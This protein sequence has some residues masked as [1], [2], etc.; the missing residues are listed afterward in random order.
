MFSK[1]DKI[2]K[3]KVDLNSNR[4]P[5]LPTGTGKMSSGIISSQLAKLIIQF[6]SILVLSRLFSPKD[7]GVVA[8]ATVGT[9]LLELVRDRGLTNILISRS[10]MGASEI[11]FIGRHQAVIA[12]V[13]WILLSCFGFVLALNPD[14]RS[15]EMG[16]LLIGAIP[17]IS[18]L[19][20]PSLVQLS[21]EKK[22]FSQNIADILGYL[23]GFACAFISA[24]NGFGVISLFLQ[25]LITSFVS[26]IVRFIAKPWRIF[27]PIS[28]EAIRELNSDGRYYLASNSVVLLASNSDSL[29]LAANST[30]IFLG[31]YNRFFQIS[32]GAAGQ[33]LTSL[34]F[35]VLSQFRE[36]KNEG[37]TVRP[38]VDFYTYRIGIPA[39]AIVGCAIPFNASFVQLALGEQWVPY[40]TI[41]T[42]LSVGALLQIHTYIAYWLSLTVL[43]SSEIFRLNLKTRIP[44]ALMIAAASLLSAGAV[45]MA[46]SLGQ[47][48]IWI[49]TVRVIGGKQRV[50]FAQLS[51][52]G[53][54]VLGICIACFLFALFISNLKVVV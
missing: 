46:Y 27:G 30:S 44:A 12:S 2:D 40:S 4:S 16:F 1:N 7:F 18:S 53:F 10:K 21:I 52:S 24:I 19:Q 48:F 23:V 49:E 51:K 3:P 31:A 22:F 25:P 42:I 33:V 41:F 45:A 5:V 8:I 6:V 14:F 11:Y 17:V 28:L 35:L 37:K 20:M 32:V 54:A 50:A 36:A 43:S 15:A 47:F 34:G 9:L 29:S 26:G 13:G 39:A 38:I